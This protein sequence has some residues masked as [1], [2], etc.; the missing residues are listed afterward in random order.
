MQC[1]Y[2]SGRGFVQRLFA[3]CSPPLNYFQD[4]DT[5]TKGRDCSLALS[6][7]SRP[8]EVLA[9]HRADRLDLL[10]CSRDQDEMIE[11]IFRHAS[12]SQAGDYYQVSFD[13]D[14]DTE[15]IDGRYLLIQ[16]Q[17][18]CPD[19]DS[20]YLERDD[21][22]FCGHV[23]VR[24]VALNSESLSIELLMYTFIVFFYS[25][26]ADPWHPITG[27]VVNHLLTLRYGRRAY[28]VGTIKCWIEKLTSITIRARIF[29]SPIFL[30]VW[31]AHRSRSVR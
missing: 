11:K 12:A 16:R 23:K 9:N 21:S 8:L 29:H 27:P 2:S 7:T 13:D 19:D 1:P 22:M 14:D 20:Y 4:L 26:E 10:E 17:F 28:K 30:P 5:P 18:E 31:S 6:A 24:A 3:S 25:K 15:G